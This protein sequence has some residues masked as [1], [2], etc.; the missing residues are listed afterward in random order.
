MR[1]IVSTAVL[2]LAMAIATPLHAGSAMAK[3]TS[4]VDGN[5]LAVTLRGEEL[6]VRMHGIAVPPA[7]EGR[8]ILQRLNKEAVAFLK[9][10]L[11]DGWVYLEF[12]DTE[13]KKDA[14]G[15]V[16]AFV[17]RGSDATF[18]NEKL[19]SVGL[20][21]VN[22]KEKCSFTDAW[23]KQQAGAKAARRGIWGSFE[24]GDGAQI[25]S[26]AAQG[27]YVGS[28]IDERGS[29]APQYVTYWILLFN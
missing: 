23:V 26:G 10:Y 6:K 11:A 15:Y 5:T 3:L 14:E 18:L 4:I 7:D 16:H 29:G 19:V 17:Y 21:V 8:P 27:T 24:N 1:S 22:K 28:A 9:K 12:P 20:A 2:V 13:L 25:A